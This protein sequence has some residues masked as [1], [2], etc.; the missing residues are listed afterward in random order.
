MIVRVCVCVCVCVCM[1]VCV[2]ACVRACVCV[3]INISQLVADPGFP[4]G[5]Q[6]LLFC[7]I[8]AE[9]YMKIKEFLPREGNASLADLLLPVVSFFS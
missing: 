5:L 6:N 4:R 9:S 2:R 8:F 1:R 3:Q 7:K